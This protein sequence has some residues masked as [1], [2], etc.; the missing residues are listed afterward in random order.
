[1]V[2]VPGTVRSSLATDLDAL[3]RPVWIRRDRRPVQ[4]EQARSVWSRPDRRRAPGCGSDG[5]GFGSQPGPAPAPPGGT[6][7]ATTSQPTST[8]PTRAEPNR[9]DAA[10]LPSNK[11]T[12]SVRA[13]RPRRP[14]RPAAEPASRLRWWVPGRAGGHLLWSAAF[15]LSR[16][17]PGRGGPY[18]QPFP[19]CIYRSAAC[20]VGPPVRRLV[21]EVEEVRRDRRATPPAEHPSPQPAG[22]RRGVPACAGVRD[23]PIAA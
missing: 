7:T 21:S 20:L 4:P 15:A 13:S 3:T 9:A 23:R 22:Q 2:V 19:V 8:G 14:R 6:T 17:W 16:P 10:G 5:W 1:M 12:G 18:F 11:V